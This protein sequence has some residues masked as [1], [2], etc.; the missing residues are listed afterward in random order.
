MIDPNYHH[1]DK[2]PEWNP[3]AVWERVAAVRKKD[4][5]KLIVV[6]VMKIAAIGLLLLATFWLVN[7]M[8]K[9]LNH[10]TRHAKIILPLPQLHLSLIEQPENFDYLTPVLPT[11]HAVEKQLVSIKKSPLKSIPAETEII[12]NNSIREVEFSRSATSIA[13]LN[14]T[15]HPL[16]NTFIP[17][18]IPTKQKPLKGSHSVYYFPLLDET[19]QEKPSFGQVLMSLIPFRKKDQRIQTNLVL[20]GENGLTVSFVI[21]QDSIK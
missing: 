13:Q 9:D 17:N 4:R 6:R 12:K 5:R 14:T 10:S 11:Y 8:E 21:R 20:D 15:L 18:F 3:E 19:T 1:F 16:P 7:S 2:S